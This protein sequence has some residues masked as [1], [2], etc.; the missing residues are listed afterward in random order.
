MRMVLLGRWLQTG[1]DCWRD[2]VVDH[3]AAMGRWEY[4]SWIAWRKG[5]KN[6]NSI[7]DLSYGENAYTLVLVYDV[8]FD[9]L[10]AGERERFCAMARER[11]VVPFLVH[12]REAQWPEWHKKANNNWNGVCAGGAG[13]L[14]LAMHEDLSEADDV[15]ELVEQSLQPFFEGLRATD[16]AWPEGIGYWNY[17]M[18]YALLYLL[19][20]ERATGKKHPLFRS[21]VMKKTI[22]FPVDFCPNGV[23]TSFGDVNHWHPHPFHFAVAERLGMSDVVQDLDRIALKTKYET[24]AWD[25][26]LEYLLMHPR[27]E[28]TASAGTDA[29]PVLRRYRGQDW[30]VLA[31]RMPNPAL[32]MSIRG[33]TT[34][35][36]HAHMDLMSYHLV[37]NDEALVPNHGVQGDMY[38]DSVWGE[39]RYEVFEFSAA[40]KNTLLANGVGIAK[41]SAVKTSTFSHGA[42]HGVRIDATGALGGEMV[43]YNRQPMVVFCGRLYLMLAARAFLLID[44]VVY[45]NVGVV[46]SRLHTF[47]DLDAHD[48]GALLNGK[49]E[50]LRVAYAATESCMCRTATAPLTRPQ[51]AD[52][53]MLR[54]CTRDTVQA[55]TMATLL[56]PGDAPASVEIIEDRGG[57]VIP[58]RGKGLDA[59][60][61]VSRTLRPNVS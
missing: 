33:G 12:V 18:S 44:R 61:R 49:R 32:Y 14:A 41:G 51:A 60:I 6:P 1:G 2:A 52:A 48:C 20:A 19:S 26:S 5:D 4:W 11:V 24:R 40:S 46:E 38:L 35:V 56:V 36:G 17:G 27:R 50:T 21:G 30:C 9:A 13:M 7:F 8:L 16:G 25:P 55:V 42:I 57:W 54:W 29:S 22:R 47:A 58:V 53:Y 45:N 23:P 39:R 15:L 43:V 34:Q 59:R 28:A 10:S 3:V 37:V 31:D